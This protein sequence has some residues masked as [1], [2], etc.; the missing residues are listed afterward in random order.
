M[1]MQLG[2]RVRC[3]ISLHLSCSSLAQQLSVVNDALAPL[4]GFTISYYAEI[5]SLDSVTIPPLNNRS[6]EILSHALLAS[7]RRNSS[8]SFQPSL[9]FYPQPLSVQQVSWWSRA[10]PWG[11]I[12]MASCKLSS[13]HVKAL[14][15]NA[16]RS[17]HLSY[18]RDIDDVAIDHLAKWAGTA[19]R[20]EAQGLSFSV[21]GVERLIC[22]CS[23]KC[24]LTLW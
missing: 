3:A 4:V 8:F 19:F 24:T 17:L 23:H 13:A 16:V 11:T 1:M 2:A 9:R 21:R 10:L 20:L 22:A 6:H 14:S 18:N 7:F 5:I 15:L 12:S